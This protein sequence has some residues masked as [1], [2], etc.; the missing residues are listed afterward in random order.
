MCGLH[1]GVGSA[2]RGPEDIHGDLLHT[3]NTLA[4]PSGIR[5]SVRTITS[6]TRSQFTPKFPH[7]STH[8]LVYLCDVLLVRLP[9]TDVE[10]VTPGRILLACMQ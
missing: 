2:S 9:Q 4:I 5:T 3:P 1:R 7:A 10:R 6:R 8:D